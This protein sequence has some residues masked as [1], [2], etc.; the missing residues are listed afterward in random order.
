MIATPVRIARRQTGRPSDAY[1]KAPRLRIYVH[2]R[3]NLTCLVLR[4]LGKSDEEGM[5]EDSDYLH[6]CI[7]VHRNA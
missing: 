5:N 2:V 1:F 7:T 6:K 4:R 3:V